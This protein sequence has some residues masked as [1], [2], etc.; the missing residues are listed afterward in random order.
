[1]LRAT[2]AIG[3]ALVLGFVGC[4][5]SGTEAT[6]GDSVGLD[7]C[8][9]PT[10]RPPEAVFDG[11]VLSVGSRAR[12][13]IDLVVG[14]TDRVQEGAVVETLPETASGDAEAGWRVLGFVD[15]RLSEPIVLQ[16]RVGSSGSTICDPSVEAIAAQDAFAAM[17]RPD[18][19][20][21]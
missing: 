11:T 3:V 5:Q 4:G 21:L 12:V 16:V 20:G 18:C 8:L 9:C 13:R 7:A 14:T 6:G 17:Q 15:G 1:M 10:S 2:L 19:P